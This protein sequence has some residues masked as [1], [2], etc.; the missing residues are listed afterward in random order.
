MLLRSSG[1]LH[2]RWNSC[3]FYS[4][5]F[6]DSYSNVL[7]ITLW[8]FSVNCPIIACVQNHVLSLLIDAW[9][10][11]GGRGGDTGTAGFSWALHW[12]WFFCLYLLKFMN[13]RAYE[14]T[15]WVRYSVFMLPV[16]GC[17]IVAIIEVT[18]NHRRAPSREFLLIPLAHPLK[19]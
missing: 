2:C 15:V 9:A 10:W 3:T 16:I 14:L 12:Y 1:L 5:A 8:S 18:T 4:T 13:K 7:L 19:H 6:F 17:F 11:A